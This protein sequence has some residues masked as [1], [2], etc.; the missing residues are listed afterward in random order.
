M[1][2]WDDT[3]LGIGCRG[4]TELW[5]AATLYGALHDAGLTVHC[6]SP[7]PAPARLTGC[8]GGRQR[9]LGTR[10]TG[11]YEDGR[12]GGEEGDEYVVADAGCGMNE[13][14]PRAPGR[15]VFGRGIVRAGFAV[16]LLLSF[17]W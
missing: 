16:L 9:E 3:L 7:L 13:D 2:Q 14:Q 10:T 15:P 6:V 1:A 4:Q 8:V 5:V 17:W 11:V 12:R